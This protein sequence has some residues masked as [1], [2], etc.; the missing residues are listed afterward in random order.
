M[1]QDVTAVILAGGEGRRFKPY[2]DIIP[3]PLMPIGPEEKP[4]L[5]HI[6]RWIARHGVKDIVFL[7]GYRWRQVANYFGRGE[8]WGI[9]IS[10]S[11]DDDKYT[12]T[13]GALLK[14]FKTGLIRSKHI[15]VWY[16][17]ILAPVDL[18]RLFSEHTSSDAVATVVVT[19]KYQVPVGVAEI[20]DHGNIVKLEEKPWI[21][22][23]VTIGV[24]MLR[25][26]SLENTEV[27]LGTS[28][29][30][31]G[32]FIPWMIEK[33]LRVRAFIHNRVWYD[34]GSLERYQKLDYDALRE[35]F[36]P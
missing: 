35:F 28:F 15:L 23:Y 24:L 34:V 17:D 19:D 27:E 12:N 18:A 5:E 26:T 30:I 33:G 10:Y 14:A 7:L 4:I 16:G 8:R 13:G 29:D 32:D 36:E 1:L 31:M 22:T 21:K 9:N 3:K 11:L 2:T 6:V 25:S 20:D